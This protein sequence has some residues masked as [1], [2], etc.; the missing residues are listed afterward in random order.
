MHVWAV[1]GH[2][3]SYNFLLMQLKLGNMPPSVFLISEITSNNISVSIQIEAWTHIRQEYRFRFCHEGLWTRNI[4]AFCAM[5]KGKVGASCMYTY[6]LPQTTK[7]KRSHTNMYTT[8]NRKIRRQWIL[9]R[10]LHIIRKNHLIAISMSFRNKC[11]ADNIYK[12]YKR[13]SSQIVFAPSKSSSCICINNKT[14]SGLYRK[15]I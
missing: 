3:P 6:C 4:A 13:I 10:I 11:N 7:W 5:W 8:I 15:S 9:K 12:I 14:K 1:P 2:Y